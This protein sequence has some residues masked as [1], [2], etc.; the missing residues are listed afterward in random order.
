MPSQEL[1]ERD[2]AQ[3]MMNRDNLFR[4]GNLLFWYENLY[5]MQFSG[6][7]DLGAKVILEIG[8]GTSPLQHFYKN[9]ITS[10]VMNLPYLDH[11]FDCH[12]IDDYAGIPD[13][14]VNIVTMTNVLHHLSDPVSCLKKIAVKLK[15]GGCVILTEPY[16]SFL[17]RIIYKW[18]H[19]ELFQFDIDAPVLKEVKGPLSSANMAIPHMIFFSNKGWDGELKELYNF[20]RED[21]VHFSSLSYMATGG[22]SRK[23]P[24]PGW[25]YKR[26]F[27][28]DRYLAK[29]FPKLFSSFFIIKLIRK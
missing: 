12:L 11:R 27:I 23:L 20:S 1:L 18:L 22:I 17:S 19:H 2:K 28:L 16:F 6:M 25:L 5:K 14:S 4:N 26:I 24:I 9:V 21:A 15:P 29:R 7:D 8:S 13:G 10:D 3:T